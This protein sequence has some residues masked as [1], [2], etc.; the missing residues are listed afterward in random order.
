MKGLV[1][2]G[3]QDSADCRRNWTT[4][5]NPRSSG[6]GTHRTSAECAEA[7][8]TAKGG[9]RYKLARSA[10]REQGWSKT[11][12]AS[13][14]H[15]KLSPMSALGPTWERQEHLHAIVSFAGASQR[16]R[17]FRGFDIL[18]I[19][20]ATGYAFDVPEEGEEPDLEAV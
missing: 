14:L 6:I 10:M 11:D 19:K 8:R 7:A 12:I 2:G 17:S 15:V 5:L 18:T 16:R 3:A 20:W 13:L 1:G 4:A 9:G